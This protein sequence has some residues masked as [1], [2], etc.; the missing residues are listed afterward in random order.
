MRQSDRKRKRSLKRTCEFFGHEYP[1]PTPVLASS[2]HDVKFE[3]THTPS[4]QH[5]PLNNTTHLYTQS[6]DS[7]YT[8]KSD[9]PPDYIHSFSCRSVDKSGYSRSINPPET[10]SR[11]SLRA[12]SFLLHANDVRQ[13]AQQ[14]TLKHVRDI[15]KFN[16]ID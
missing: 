13:Y 3:S 16:I 12:G 2:F 5:L 4:A 8:P 11:S 1:A 7:Q 10:S 14:V 6:N 15:P 9:T